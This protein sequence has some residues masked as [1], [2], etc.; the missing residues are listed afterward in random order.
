[1]TATKIAQTVLALALFVGSLT[2]A[3]SGV[4]EARP[5]SD[6][7]RQT[8]QKELENYI[9]GLSS[10]YGVAVVNLTDG[11]SVSVNDEDAFPTASLYKLL[12]M[13]R[14]F[15]AIDN[16]ELSLG[17][18]LTIQ[19]GDLKAGDPDVAFA[20][21]DT[22]TVG[23][24]LD[25]MITVSSNAAAYALVRAVG[26]WY[27]IIT[28]ADA[29]GMGG[30]V[31]TD[32]FWSTPDDIAHFLHLLANR[33]LVS[34]SASDQMMDLLLNQQVNDRIPSL[35]PADAT[36]AHKTGELPG[37]RNDVGI[38]RCPGAE[39]IIVT[40]SRGGDPAEEVPVEARISRMVYDEYCG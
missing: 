11:R 27:R 13:Y 16:G 15:Q 19:P 6:P 26:G 38:V 30:T 29:L 4:A 14:V 22:T 32:D 17:D 25:R 31:F 1:M 2:S 35:L 8:L 10:T 39:Y 9:G 24:A 21:G 33:S 36:V 12:V 18:Q 3:F 23:H 37:V 28:A 34:P 5:H 20:A 40:M 7:A